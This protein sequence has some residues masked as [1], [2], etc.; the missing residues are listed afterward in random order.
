M[1]TAKDDAP[2]AEAPK[3]DT[4]SSRVIIQKTDP[5]NTDSHAYI[6]FNDFETQVQFDK[7]VTLPNVVITYL[8]TLTRTTFNP[9]EKGKP[10]A[11]KTRMFSI[12]S[13]GK[14]D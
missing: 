7:P 11:T 13:A 4:G 9:D 8:K 2:K 5:T 10:R 12:V 3:A 14:D 6:G 1:A